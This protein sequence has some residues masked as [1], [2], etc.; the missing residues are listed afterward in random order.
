MIEQVN[1]GKSNHYPIRQQI[2]RESPNQY[3]IGP[4]LAWPST[5]R[6][7]IPESQKMK[8]KEGKITTLNVGRLDTVRKNVQNGKDS[9]RK[10]FP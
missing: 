3:P 7:K 9:V 1:R 2:H 5:S 10:L 8:Q 4:Q 6:Y